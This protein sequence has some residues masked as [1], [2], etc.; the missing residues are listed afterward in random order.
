MQL[1]HSSQSQYHSRSLSTT[2]V[3]NFINTPTKSNR[4]VRF[5]DSDSKSARTSATSIRRYLDNYSHKSSFPRSNGYSTPTKSYAVSVSQN[6]DKSLEIYN[7][8]PAKNDDSISKRSDP[9]AIK[10]GSPLYKVHSSSFTHGSGVSM[11]KRSDPSVSKSE[12]TTPRYK[13]HS[14]NHTPDSAFLLGSSKEGSTPQTPKTRNANFSFAAKSNIVA[15]EG[16]TLVNASKKSNAEN[17]SLE[18]LIKNTPPKAEVTY[19]QKETKETTHAQKETTEVISFQQGSPRTSPKS[20]SVVHQKR[21][22]P[23]KRYTRSLIIH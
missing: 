13:F 20:Q 6:S 3:S 21:E 10:S 8:E 18:T 15:D 11:A 2:P 19:T 23:N 9:S 5:S 4:H 1:E 7:F 14:S 12:K 16:G 22:Q 17:G